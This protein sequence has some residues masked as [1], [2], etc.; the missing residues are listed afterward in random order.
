MAYLGQWLT[1]PLARSFQDNTARKLDRIAGHSI[2][3]FR[4]RFLIATPNG[5]RKVGMQTGDLCEVA[6]PIA[7]NVE[8]TT[9]ERMQRG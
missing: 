9:R 3:A 1:P 6:E 8:K 4:C 2:A 5:L 7:V